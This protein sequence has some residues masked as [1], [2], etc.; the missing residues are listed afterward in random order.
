LDVGWDDRAFRWL[1]ASTW[2]AVVLACLALA[3]AP[4][5]AQAAPPAK[6]A[7]TPTPWNTGTAPPPA[8]RPAEDSTLSLRLYDEVPGRGK[9]PYRPGPPRRGDPALAV[10]VSAVM[11]RCPDGN[12]V[13]TALVIGGQLT[14]LDNRCPGERRQAPATPSGPTPRCD[15]NT[16]NCSTSPAP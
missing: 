10:D 13:I 12:L 3:S 7:S 15:A 11:T 14:P 1:A 9:L 5:P 8:P 6:T 4:A 2:V 16:W